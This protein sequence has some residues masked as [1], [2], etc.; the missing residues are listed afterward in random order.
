VGSVVIYP[1]SKKIP[2]VNLLTYNMQ[3]LPNFIIIGAPKSGTT[4]LYF[5]LRQHPDIYL[6][7]EK[8]L[9]YFS[10]SYEAKNLN[11]AGDSNA[12]NR[13]YHS[14]ATYSQ[15]Y[16]EV[17][18]QTAIGE[19]SPNYFYYAT[20]V[21]KS[22]HQQL[23]TV[24][25]III[26]RNPVDK[27]YSQYMHLVRE[28]RETLDFYQ[29]LHTER[30]NWAD[31]WRYAESSLYTQRVKAYFQL[32][33]K[34][35]VKVILF[36]NLVN[37]TQSILTELFE[38]LEINPDIKCDTS[39]IYNRTGKPYSKSLANLLTNANMMKRIG[40]LFIPKPV[41]QALTL[42]MVDLNTKPKESMDNLSR[43]Y[44]KRFF[45]NDIIEL[46]TLLDCKTGW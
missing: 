28:G 11:G 6:P 23:G 33:G 38:F 42:K 2:V 46:D 12:F 14:W 18:H 40:K 27:T 34:K 45:E 44:L 37:H 4:S 16:A 9:N 30:R 20:Q 31:V 3:K 25:I 35:N 17:Q 21:G 8:E 7:P 32:F 22:I 36:H 24:K 41:R 19:I 43:E 5:Y 10:K 26:L 1:C 29:A 15:Q 39:K 13:G